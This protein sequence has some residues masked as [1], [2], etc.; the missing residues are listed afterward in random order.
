[1]PMTQDETNEPR[2][3]H[4][5]EDAASPREDLA[6]PQA[7]L[8]DAADAEDIDIGDGAREPDTLRDRETYENIE[9]GPTEV[10][11][12]ETKAWDREDEV[13]DEDIAEVPE[14]RRQRLRTLQIIGLI[15]VNL[16]VLLVV[17][18]MLWKAFA[19]KDQVNPPA[20]IP[21]ERQ[22]ASSDN[23][24]TPAGPRRR[25]RARS[26]CNAIG[27]AFSRQMRSPQL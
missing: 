13:P 17:V 12:Y 27:H 10:V 19:S 22:K 11:S 3:E 18:Y 2:Q 1:M 15:L 14:S 16:A 5:P 23:G 7:P 8:S 25:G 9:P 6:P 4:E 21:A 26:H 20:P 24:S